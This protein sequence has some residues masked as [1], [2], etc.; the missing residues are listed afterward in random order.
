MTYRQRAS[1]VGVAL[2]EALGITRSGIRQEEGIDIISSHRTP[3]LNSVQP[4]DFPVFGECEHSSLGANPLQPHSL[5]LYS[6]KA[7]R[8]AHALP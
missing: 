4:A 8:W 6:T 2:A 1:G 5:F 3:T 7:L